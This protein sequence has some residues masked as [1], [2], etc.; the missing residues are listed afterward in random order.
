MSLNKEKED[1]LSKQNLEDGEPQYRIE[2]NRASWWWNKYQEEAER[3]QKKV[4]G[5]VIVTV[6]KHRFKGNET[7]FQFLDFSSWM[8]SC[9]PYWLL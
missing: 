1:N 9:L 8:I 2:D 6:V 7:M 4:E 5:I 3:E